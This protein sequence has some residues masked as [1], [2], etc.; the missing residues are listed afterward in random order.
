MAAKS[1][2]PSNTAVKST[3]SVP[4]KN[5][6]SSHAESKTCEPSGASA[7]ATVISFKTCVPFKNTDGVSCYANSVLQSLLQHGALRNAFIA[8]RYRALRE[9]SNSYNNPSRREVL[10]SRKVRCMLG[11]PFSVQRQQDASEFLVSLSMYCRTIEQY[12]TV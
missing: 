2:D 11:A 12:K 9:L 6:T 1:T 7:A 3:P 5:V 8:S 4:M 10:S